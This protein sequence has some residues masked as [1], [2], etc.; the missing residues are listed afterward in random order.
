MAKLS[1]ENIKE[2][3]IIV[4]PIRRLGGLDN[5]HVALIVLVGILVLLLLFISY[6]KQTVYI[7]SNQTNSTNSSNNT[8]IHNA[9]QVKLSVE[10]LLA[11]YG[12]VNGSI[13]ALPYS[14][15]V[16]AMNVT[17]L[18]SDK[19]WYVSVPLTISS[20]QPIYFSALVSDANISDII[21]SLQTVVPSQITKNYVISDGIVK[22][23]GQF[24]CTTLNPLKVYWFVDPYAP[25]GITTLSNL[26]SLE[27]QFGSKVNFSVEILFTQYYGQVAKQYG[28]NKTQ[29]LGGYLYC[30]SQQGP[31]SFSRFVSALNSVYSS[32]FVSPATLSNLSTDSD[33]NASI[34]N[35]CLATFPTKASAQAQLAQYYSIVAT[36]SVLTSCQYVSIPQTT[37]Q[38]ICYAN[39]TL[40]LS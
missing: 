39:S 3:S 21:P 34:L 19:A 27:Q 36:P 30:A 28:A 32:A 12:A 5:I 13:S 20:T 17:Y 29:E 26:T 8:P 6:T 23:A 33:L 40:C 4:K 18:P 1:K 9:S 24:G 14:S 35:N 31:S 38:A 11:S 25:G 10:K 2:P 15:N 37:R 16:T 7:H 22:L